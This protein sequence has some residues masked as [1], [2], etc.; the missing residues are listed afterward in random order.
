[1][2]FTSNFKHFQEKMMVIANVF[3]KLETVN[4]FIRPLCKK[5]RFGKCFDSQ[6]VKVSQIL[7][8]SPWERFYHV[9]SSYWEKLIWKWSLVLLS[10]ISRIFLNTSPACSI[11]RE[12]V[13]PN[14]NAMISK[15]KNFSQFLVPFMESISNF[16]HFLIKGWS[17]KLMY[18]RS[19]RL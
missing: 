18:F 4:I 3:P 10:Q 7:A 13:I 2:E 14:S 8:K 19:H 11:L 17:P 1:M 5:C 15:Q 16:R 9:F 6:H 12:F